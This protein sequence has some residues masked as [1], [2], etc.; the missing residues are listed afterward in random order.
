MMVE[1][2]ERLRRQ[3]F[4]LSRSRQGRGAAWEPPVDIF[5]DENGLCVTV[6]LPGVGPDDMEVILDGNLLIVAGRRKLPEMCRAAVIH[7]IELPHGRF[8]RCIALPW[9][10]WRLGRRELANGCLVVNV[11][12][13]EGPRT[14]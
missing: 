1:R 5:E 4:E 3:F 2:A 13:A 8:E 12:A 14:A 11:H 7:R 6:A 10:R 9:R